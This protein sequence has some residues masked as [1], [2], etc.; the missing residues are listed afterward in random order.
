MDTAVCVW[1]IFVS[2]SVLAP[3]RIFISFSLV[4]CMSVYLPRFAEMCENCLLYKEY[5]EEWKANKKLFKKRKMI[6]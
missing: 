6:E 5:V 3:N 1:L 4:H 2:L